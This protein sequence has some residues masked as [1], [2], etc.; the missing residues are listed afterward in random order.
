MF[1]RHIA[2]DLLLDKATPIPIQEDPRDEYGGKDEETDSVG[3]GDPFDSKA[4]TPSDE[5]I[6]GGNLRGKILVG[7]LQNN[8]DQPNH[9]VGTKNGGLQQEITTFL[10]TVKIRFQKGGVM[11][12]RGK[13]HGRYFA[14]RGK[15]VRTSKAEMFA[16]PEGVA[17]YWVTK[18]RDWQQHTFTRRNNA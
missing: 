6:P 16:T 18:I 11:R 17:R 10:E 15:L 5:D 14:L 3:V 13:R 4:E 9:L 2:H 8:G 12:K 1:R 7:S